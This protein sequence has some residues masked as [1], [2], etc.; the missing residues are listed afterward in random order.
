MPRVFQNANLK[1]TLRKRDMQ[2]RDQRHEEA[3]ETFQMHI[4]IKEG[5]RPF[6]CF[7]SVNAVY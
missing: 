6:Y 4:Y 7:L 2:P 3:I 1:N 5:K